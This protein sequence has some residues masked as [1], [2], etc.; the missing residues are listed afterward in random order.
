LQIRW[1]HLLL[2][3]MGKVPTTFLW[4]RAILVTSQRARILEQLSKHGRTSFDVML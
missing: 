1:A 2:G 4:Q 3:A